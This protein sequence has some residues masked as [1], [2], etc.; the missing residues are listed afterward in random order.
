LFERPG[1]K[2]LAVILFTLLIHPVHAFSSSESDI[3]SEYL[4]KED[5][6]SGLRVALYPYIT[7]VNRDGNAY[8]ISIMKEQF[9]SEHPMI[10]LTLYL[11]S[12]YDCYNLTRLPAIFS[13]EGPQL[14]ETDLSL[15]GYLVDNGYVKPYPDT[16]LLRNIKSQVVPASHYENAPYAVP[17]W[18]C[19]LF[20]FSRDSEILSIRNGTDL[21]RIFR[22][23]SGVYGNMLTGDFQG[24]TPWML[25]MVYV[26]AYTDN[27]GFQMK[28]EAIREPVKEAAIRTMAD[29]MEWCS[30]H[31]TNQCLNGDYTNISP[32]LVFARNESYSYSGF[33]E[34]LYNIRRVDQDSRV[35]MVSTPFGDHHNPLLWVDG[36]VINRKACDEICMDA[37]SSFI[38]YYNSLAVKN[39]IAFSDDAYQQAPP[40]YLLPATDNFYTADRGRSDSSY[41]QFASV[42]NS[43]ESFPNSGMVNHIFERYQDVCEQ[44]K[45]RIPGTTCICNQSP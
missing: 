25:P 32:S 45:I 43:A 6:S 18:I 41:R 5:N 38:T 27:E 12:S 14:V 10:N 1:V 28:T 37:A 22:P 3:Y 30:F 7:D 2:V 15:L 44:L 4:G 35:Y 29:T 42:I 31:G 13:E 26:F 40:R 39:M 24:G 16:S 19:S 9:Q 17:T 11:N 36:F 34:N 20:L 8:L 21:S 23:H 33:S